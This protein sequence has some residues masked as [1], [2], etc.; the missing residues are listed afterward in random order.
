AVAGEIG[1]VADDVEADDGFDLA[2]IG[3]GAAAGVVDGGG[4]G[5]LQPGGVLDQ[6]GAGVGEDV[7]V[8]LQDVGD[9]VVGLA[10]ADD[11]DHLDQAV[12]GEIG[13][14]A[15]DVEADDGFDL[16]VIGDG[17]AAGVVDGGGAGQLQAGGALDQHGAGVR[18]DVVVELQGVGGVGV[19]L[20]GD[21]AADHLDQAVAGESGGVADD[22]E[23]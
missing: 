21:G 18:E 3:D 13:G 22:V 11:A 8:E 10:G 12:A 2:V 5:Q 6:H 19:G 1:G 4:V 14:V 17:A 16:A 20:A 15:D 7:V 9:V 23:A